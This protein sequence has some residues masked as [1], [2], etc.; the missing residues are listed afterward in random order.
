MEITFTRRTAGEEFA[1]QGSETTG[2]TPPPHASP[3]PPACTRLWCWL[4]VQLHETGA[5]GGAVWL[6]GSPHGTWTCFGKIKRVYRSQKTWLLVLKKTRT[7][8]FALLAG[9]TEAVEQIGG[10]QCNYSDWDMWHAAN[11]HWS[12]RHFVS[13]ITIS[14]VPAGFCFVFELCYDDDCKI[15]MA[16]FIYFC[17]ENFSNHWS[18]EGIYKK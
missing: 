12:F 14:L 11:L 13:L 6:T 15:P 8:K 3:T 2:R 18:I 4:P 1:V 7:R 10:L 9:P 17:L 16:T 5:A